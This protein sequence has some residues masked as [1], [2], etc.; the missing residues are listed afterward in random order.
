MFLHG[1]CHSRID[2]RAREEGNEREWSC[3][4]SVS[5]CR[6][7]AQS[8]RRSQGTS[9]ACTFPQAKPAGHLGGAVYRRGEVFERVELKFLDWI[10]E[11]IVN[12][13]CEDFQ[14]NRR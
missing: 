6:W 7:R 5:R 10:M 9:K 11:A 4:L 2:D 1:K 3:D 14:E 12:R 8:Q 13:A